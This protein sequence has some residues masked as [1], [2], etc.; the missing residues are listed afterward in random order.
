MKIYRNELVRNLG[1]RKR[2]KRK[3]RT[4]CYPGSGPLKTNS[5]MEMW[6]ISG[7]TS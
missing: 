5:E 4:L 3:T 7:T 6:E 1:G 2:D